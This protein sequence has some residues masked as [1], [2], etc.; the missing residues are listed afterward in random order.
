[1]T[2][3]EIKDKYKTSV[4]FGIKETST[5]EV[6]IVD[7]Y[8]DTMYCFSDGSK[9]LFML[10]G[11]EEVLVPGELLTGIDLQEHLFTFCREII[12]LI[13]MENKDNVDEG[14]WP[15][16]YIDEMLTNFSVGISLLSLGEL[17]KT[18]NW[19]TVTAANTSWLIQTR[20]DFYLNKMNGEITRLGL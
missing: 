15:E 2:L 11:F 3:Q 6:K 8:T 16:S 14:L 19:L 4:G 9:R 18:R 12:I 13:K 20:K 17:V 1:M 5:G 10:E 7:S